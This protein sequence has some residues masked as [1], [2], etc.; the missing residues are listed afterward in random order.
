M[1]TS[2]T[3]DKKWRVKLN[4][5]RFEAGWA[6]FVEQYNLK[7]ENILVFKH[8]GD[9]EFEV[10]IFDVNESEGE[11]EEQQQ[12]KTQN[13][14]VTTSKKF[15]SKDKPD[16][17]IKSSSKTSPHTESAI[18]KPFGYSHFVCTV[19]P[20][21]LTTDILCIPKKFAFENGLFNFEKRDLIV[22][23]ERQRSWNVTLR[24]YGN[25]VNL[26][27]GWKKIRDANCLKEGDQIMF[28]VVV[29]GDKPIWKF[30]GKI[31]EEDAA[32]NRLIE[33]EYSVVKKNKKQ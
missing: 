26:K 30:H 5:R 15:E 4:G 19:R 28:E 16:H 10:S 22:R 27:G 25:C 17:N 3:A 9:M 24:S 23:D 2:L 14:E 29:G 21:C 8:E 18:H 31:S 12:Q 6:E 32:F 20:Y 7:L 11:Y 13:V 1:T 33:Q